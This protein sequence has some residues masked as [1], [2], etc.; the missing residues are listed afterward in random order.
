M[1]IVE[2]LVNTKVHVD[3]VDAALDHLRYQDVFM[4]GQNVIHLAT[5]YS[6]DCLEYICFGFG[7]FLGIGEHLEDRDYFKNTPLHLAACNT[8][9]D[10][11][12]KILDS[13]ENVKT[14]LKAKDG[15]GNTPLHIVSQRGIYCIAD[16]ICSNIHY[17]QVQKKPAFFFL[18]LQKMILKSLI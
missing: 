15:K 8:S 6:Q 4:H 16:I 18:M 13:V 14:I 5:E 9:P 3:A 1:N 12:S 10:C 7:N 17:S 11:A 2:V